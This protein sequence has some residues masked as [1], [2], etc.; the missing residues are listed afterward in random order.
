MLEELVEAV[1]SDEGDVS[2]QERGRELEER[3]R[4]RRRLCERGRVAVRQDLGLELERDRRERL[5]VECGGRH[6]GWTE[7]VVVDGGETGDEGGRWREGRARTP[8][9]CCARRRDGTRS[10]ITHRQSHRIESE[11]AM[12]IGR[13]I[14]PAWLSSA[15]GQERGNLSAILPSSDAKLVRRLSLGDLGRVD[16]LADPLLSSSLS[17]VQSC[18]RGVGENYAGEEGETLVRECQ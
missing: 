15:R 16:N 11:D 4:R 6:D 8:L 17:E 12:R 2:V 18:G 14:M 10:W 9:A 7:G 3:Q 1:R 5:E 13:E